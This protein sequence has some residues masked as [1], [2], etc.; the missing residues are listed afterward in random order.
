MGLQFIYPSFLWALLLVAIPI[1]VHL[2]NFRKFKKA[3][4]SDIRFLKLVQLQSRTENKLRNLLLLILRILCIIFLVIAFAQPYIPAKNRINDAR[5]K[6]VSIYIDN[7]FS[8]DALGEKGN[9]LEEAKKS[10]L[11]IVAGYGN[12]DKFQILTNDFEGRHQR[13]LS[14][15]DF[16]R[17]VD[18]IHISSTVRSMDEVVKRQINLLNEN[19]TTNRICYL[20][21]DFQKSTANLASIKADSSIRINFVPLHAEE[22]QNIA[23]DSCWFT[24]PFHPIY[25]NE[26]LMVKIINFSDKDIKD[27]PVRLTINKK[28]AALASCNLNAHTSTTVKLSFSNLATGIQQSTITLSDY[29]VTFDDSLY[30]SFNVAKTINALCIYNDKESRYLNSL[31]KKDSSVALTNVNQNHIDYSSLAGYQ[32]IV[33]NELEVIPSGLAQELKNFT[34]SG[35]NLLIIPNAKIATESYNLF[36]NAVHTDTY[37]E[38]VNADNKVKTINYQSLIYKEVFETIDPNMDLPKVNR[39]YKISQNTHRNKEDLLS[40]QNNDAL[41]SKYQVGKG[42]IY[43][44]AIALRD[45]FSNF[46]AHALFVPSMINIAR[47]SQPIMQPYYVLGNENL[48][49]INSIRMATGDVF[50]L[51][52]EQHTTDIIPY[53][54]TM[55]ATTQIN[56]SNQLN[57][58]NNYMLKSNNQTITNLSFNY[59]RKESDL[60]TFST[61]LLIE[62]SEKL[63]KN[64]NVLNTK[65]NS[66]SLS[67][68]EESLGKKL[69]KWFIILSLLCLAAETFVI[70]F[71]KFGKT[72]I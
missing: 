44:L 64:V 65:H 18:E 38:L 36:L 25:K 56:I 55:G 10:A 2:F 37:S 35:G 62:A 66:L 16:K 67:L 13:F 39:Y 46:Q 33:L 45:E 1:I 32:L 42:K 71:A 14:K 48:I 20:I 47:F 7:S 43:L 57:K 26:E 29:P 60:S 69:W 5:I 41:L 58:A 12:M 19:R 27:L 68:T 63:G 61:D 51:M 50:H 11:E 9:L 22:K 21:S 30:F 3:Y 72:K 52:D 6:S 28:Q 31:F 40:L 15:K 4:F 34:E 23:I 24:S 70:R 8:M 17:L 54:R 59:N 53:H 49:T